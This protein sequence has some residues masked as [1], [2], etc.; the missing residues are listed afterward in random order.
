MELRRF[1][2]EAMS[3]LSDAMAQDGK[4]DIIFKSPTGSGKTIVLTRF[5]SEFMRGHKKTVFVWLT[6]GE[7]SLEEQSKAKMDRYCA[8]ASTKLLSDVMTGGFAAGDAVFINWQKLNKDGKAACSIFIMP[9][10]I[11][12]LQKRLEGRGTDAPEV[13]AKRVAKAEF[14]I[15][16]SPEF[17]HKVINDDLATAVADTRAIIDAFLVK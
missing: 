3:R 14:E 4:C 9:P 1:Q 15:S 8:G 7:G 10:S 16:K 2:L 11:E 5:M 17:D 13:I 12:E 6:P